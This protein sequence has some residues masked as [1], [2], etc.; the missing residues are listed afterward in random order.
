M[1]VAA[2]PVGELLQAETVGRQQ[3]AADAQAVNV[4][5]DR[6]AVYA[7]GQ[8]A[9]LAAE[10][11]QHHGE[12]IGYHPG[13]DL[14][15]RDQAGHTHAPLVA[16]QNQ[17]ER[18]DAEE[19]AGEIG[20]IG[21]A[22]VGDA[23]G[24][25]QGQPVALILEKALA[26]AVEAFILGTPEAEQHREGYELAGGQHHMPGHPLL[27]VGRHTEGDT[28]GKAEP[29]AHAHH[30]EHGVG[31]QRVGK[32]D[33]QHIQVEHDAG[34]FRKQANEPDEDIINQVVV[35][36][37]FARDLIERPA[38]GAGQL[39]VAALHLAHPVDAVAAVE[40]GHRPI[41]PPQLEKPVFAGRHRRQQQ[42]DGQSFPGQVLF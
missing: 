2:H 3:Q 25:S 22:V 7:V 8:G 35:R 20:I 30:A 19:K 34:V 42:R 1:E 27:H 33:D 5:A 36:V 26:R 9:A 18:G 15:D 32:G 28:K 40:H 41:E 13:N 23:P 31:R 6:A 24:H 14:R 12:E 38:Q 21:R 17:A 10:D 39:A 37:I 16:A 11:A 4:R 29:A